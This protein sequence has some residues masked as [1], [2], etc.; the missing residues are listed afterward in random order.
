[1]LPGFFSNVV[2]LCHFDMKVSITEC[3]NGYFCLHRCI[4]LKFFVDI[5]RGFFNRQAETAQSIKI[6]VKVDIIHIVFVRHKPYCDIS[7]VIVFAYR[8][9][10]INAFVRFNQIDFLKVLYQLTSTPA[11]VFLILNPFV[12]SDKLNFSLFVLACSVIC[13]SDHFHL[14]I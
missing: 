12:E 3:F 2:T 7:R 10:Q 13:G 4:Q 5:F 9:I 11:K 1:M 6:L 14:P 8:A